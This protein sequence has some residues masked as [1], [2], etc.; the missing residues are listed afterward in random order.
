LA[1]LIMALTQPGD[2]VAMEP[3]VYPGML[4]V[5]QQLGRRIVV[6]DCDKDGMQPDA[7]A[8]ACR[9]HGAKVVYLNPTLQNPTTH[10]MPESRRRDI[11][12]VIRECG[13]QLIE[14]DP[15]WRLADHPPAPVTHAIPERT[16]YIATL[17]K[18]LAP[19]MRTAYVVSPDETAQARFLDALHTIALMGAPFTTAVATQWM[20]DGTAAQVLEAV[21]VESCARLRLAES[22][23]GNGDQTWPASGIHVWYTLPEPWTAQSLVMVARAEGLAVTASDSFSAGGRE[24]N[25]IRLSFGGV[26]E[27]G[28]LA[29]GLEKLMA[30]LKRGE[31][32]AAQ[33]VV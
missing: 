1:S 27:R 23:L 16:Y 7:L 30:I 33:V 28:Q 22:V 29:Q 32:D 15:Y 10:T 24:A 8:R 4:G 19:G 3:L 20:H 18:C 2:G 31:L 12:R 13:M 14:D 6:V 21:K 25:A 9:E 17:S 26:R 5:A 11:A